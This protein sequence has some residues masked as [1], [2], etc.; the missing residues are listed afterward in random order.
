MHRF[1]LAVS[2]RSDANMADAEPEMAEEAGA[3]A[4]T[5]AALE[6]T[7]IELVV[8]VKGERPV[9]KSATSPDDETDGEKRKKNGKTS[10]KTTF[11]YK[12]W[13]ENDMAMAIRAW[14]DGGIS[15]A[16]AAERFCVPPGTLNYRLNGT[17]LDGLKS[18][19]S[20]LLEV[21]TENEV[22]DYASKRAEL[23]IR[24]SK[25]N[26]KKY[27]SEIA[28]K[29][30]KVFKNALLSER[31]W[32]QIKR[33]HK[34]PLLNPFRASA[35]K[36]K[37]M[38]V[39]KVCKYFS[40]LKA[41]MDTHQLNE[42]PHCIWS[43]D[44]VELLLEHRPS[45]V[46]RGMQSETSDLVQPTTIVGCG[47]A[48]GDA[49]PPFV[50]VDEKTS[51]SLK[52][53]DS[54]NAPPGTTLS[55][56]ASGWLRDG[57]PKLWFKQTFLA[58]IGHERPQVL[59]LD[60]R[61]ARYYVELADVAGE[62]NIVLVELPEYTSHW[63]QPLDR[64]IFGP[65]KLAWDCAAA[66]VL[67]NPAIAL[68]KKQYFLLFGKAWH[69]SFMPVLVRNGF[70]QTGIFPFNPRAI[71]QK[72]FISGSDYEKVLIHVGINITVDAADTAQQL[73]FL[74]EESSKDAITE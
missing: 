66:E 29:K 71:P 69:A 21:E 5:S 59:I 44:K 14:E 53:F 31:W 19:P 30:G 2:Q 42:K 46:V 33:R 9:K 24:F 48:A 26:F 50:V 10:R 67:N 34:I 55:I 27:V 65:M 51:N 32:S 37:G 17:R 40:A 8:A 13:D 60:G 57:L 25:T 3:G 1:A 16:Q 56:S 63:L 72:A 47:N 28:K 54:R 64:A 38:E 20:P 15:V 41:I 18:G 43:M 4:E 7:E 68:S 52:D 73:V 36:R 6:E 58:N 61:A 11:R 12:T 35:I 45:N 22:A 49:L 62:N 23:G 39:S 74:D 70:G